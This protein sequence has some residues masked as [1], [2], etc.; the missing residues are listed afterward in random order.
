MADSLEQLCQGLERGGI[1]AGQ[2]RKRNHV[3]FDNSRD[4]MLTFTRRKKPDL[5]QRIAE[6]RITVIGQRLRF[7]AKSTC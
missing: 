1:R 2:W 6:V 4:E 5:K 7:N 3:A